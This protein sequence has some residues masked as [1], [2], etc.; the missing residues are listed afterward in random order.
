MAWAVGGMREGGKGI[1]GWSSVD[2][3]GEFVWGMWKVRMKHGVYVCQL[4]FDN[5]NVQLIR[6]FLSDVND[7][8]A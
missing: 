2:D 4:V 5:I 7:D 8:H 6:R 1:V 3:N